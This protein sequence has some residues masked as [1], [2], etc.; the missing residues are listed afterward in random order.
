MLDSLH[1]RP[2]IS[3]ADVNP[4]LYSYVNELTIIEVWLSMKWLLA[5]V[6]YTVYVCFIINFSLETT[7]KFAG[8]EAH[9]S[10]V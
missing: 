10:C 8:Y 7:K 5:N 6:L 9:P 2:L 1:S 4:S 3:I